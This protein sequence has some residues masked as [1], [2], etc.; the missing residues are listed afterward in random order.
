MKFYSETLDKLFNT[1][2]ELKAAEVKVAEEK[3]KK[4]Q[5]AAEKKADAAKVEEAFKANNEAKREYNTKVLAARKTYNE[6]VAA[7]TKT[8][9]SALADA[10]AVKANA[11]KAFDSALKEFTKKY[12]SYHM[13]LRDGDNIVTLSSIEQLPENRAVSSFDLFDK[14]FELLKF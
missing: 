3:A 2:E 11:E 12:G 10:T 13:T 9:D 14:L 5:T 7:A 1:E 8:F 6:A 4:E